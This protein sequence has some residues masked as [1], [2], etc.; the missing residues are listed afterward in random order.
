MRL[1]TSPCNSACRASSMRRRS[2]RRAIL[3]L[4]VMGS[5]CAFR[6]ARSVPK[7][8]WAE[9]PACA[10]RDRRERCPGRKVHTHDGQIHSPVASTAVAVSSVH[11]GHTRVGSPLER[12]PILQR[13]VGDAVSERRPLSLGSKGVLQFD[14]TVRAGEIGPDGFDACFCVASQ[15]VE[16]SAKSLRRRRRITAELTAGGVSGRAA[17]N[18]RSIRPSFIL[19][20]IAPR[21]TRLRDAPPTD[22]VL[23]TWAPSAPVSSIE[24]RPSVFRRQPSN[25]LCSARVSQQGP[26]S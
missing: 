25:R 21:P 26:D 9:E 11:V 1:R 2:S 19:S 5:A 24:S 6:R 8:T 23:E 13:T 22:E 17:R 7:C 15:V 18:R 12:V 3:R 10:I 16:A 4:V 20:R 14:V